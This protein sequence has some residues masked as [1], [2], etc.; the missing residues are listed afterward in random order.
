MELALS[1]FWVN[2]FMEHNQ[3]S[4]N[5][6]VIVDENQALNSQIYELYMQVGRVES[7]CMLCFE[8]VFLTIVF[9]V[10]KQCTKRHK[11]VS[12]TKFPS[13]KLESV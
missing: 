6:L 5:V 13:V 11:Y 12:V 8:L 9:L 2:T 7:L 4:N 10:L 3:P 1:N